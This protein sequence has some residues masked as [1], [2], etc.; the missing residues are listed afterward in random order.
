MRERLNQYAGVAKT[1]WKTETKTNAGTVMSGTLLVLALGV[2]FGLVVLGWWLVPVQWEPNKMGDIPYESKQVYVHVLSE[3][4]AYSQNDVAMMRYMQEVYDIAD[5]ACDMANDA[6][7]VGTMRRYIKV[8][9]L[10]NGE[11]C[12]Q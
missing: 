10:A 3:W 2:I 8:A 6:D 1:I 5:V 11:G 4:Y 7:D 9:Y 12:P